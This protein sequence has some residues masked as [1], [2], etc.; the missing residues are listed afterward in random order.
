MRTRSHLAAVI[1]ALSTACSAA[2]GPLPADDAAA[3]ADAPREAACGPREA[4]RGGECIAA[5]DE[6]CGRLR[7]RCVAPEHCITESDYDGGL[8]EPRCAPLW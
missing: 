5:A 7:R 6:A 4:L 1:L 8:T 2:A 3:P